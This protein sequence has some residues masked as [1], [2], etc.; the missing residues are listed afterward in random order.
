MREKTIIFLILF[1]LRPK[2]ASILFSGILPILQGTAEYT[3]I[4][5]SPYPDT[6]TAHSSASQWEWLTSSSA[7][8]IHLITQWLVI[9]VW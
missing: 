5:N 9:Q 3:S 2:P 1:R 8:S 7:S 4:K 6:S